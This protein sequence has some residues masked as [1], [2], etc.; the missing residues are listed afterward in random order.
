MADLGS[1]YCLSGRS[2]Y[3]AFTSFANRQGT[4]GFEGFPDLEGQIPEQ[5]TRM[6]GVAYITDVHKIYL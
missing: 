4:A 5:F 1:T 2:V 3:A 6:T